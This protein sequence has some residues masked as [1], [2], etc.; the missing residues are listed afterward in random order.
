MKVFISVDMEGICGANDWSDVTKDNSDYRQIQKQMTAET[1]AACNGAIDG[2]AT[3][4]VVRDAHDSARNIIASE[5]PHNTTLIR[6]WSRHPYMMMQGLDSS[7]DCA[8]MI[9]YHTFAGG[10]GNPLAHTMNTGTNS[11]LLLNGKLASEFTIN[12]YTALYEKVPVLFVSGDEEL[13][14]HAKET[15]PGITATAVKSGIGDST[16]NLHP[17]KALAAIES[18]V[19]EALTKGKGHSPAELPDLFEATLHFTNHKDAYKTSFY[20]GVDLTS[21]RTAVFRAADYFD[22]LRFFLFNL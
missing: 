22:V 6:G 9:G 16:I 12:Y 8:L 20:P 15:D 7:F 13:C 17:D 14:N 10:A 21:P 18:G 19:R 4:I 1:V 5:L 11:S 2:G 3:E